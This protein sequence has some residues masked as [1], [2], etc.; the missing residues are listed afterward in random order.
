MLQ[1]QDPRER[2]LVA[3]ADTVLATV[4]LPASLF[5]RR[6]VSAP[7]RILLLRLE[8]IGDLLMTLPAIAAVRASAPG[9]DIDL[10]VGGWNAPIAACIPGLRRV[11]TLDA[12]WLARGKNAL[13]FAA[14]AARARRWRRERYDLAIN[15]EGDI[16]SN[17]LMWL[18]G[19]P[20]RAGFDMAG[21]G[22]LLTDAVAFD[23]RRHVS[24]NAMRLVAV[25]FAGSPGTGRAELQLPDD[26]R[27]AAEQLLAPAS[28]NGD[29]RPLVGI[30]ASGGRAI[31]QW[32]AERFAEVARLLREQRGAS[33][34]LTGTPDERALVSQVAGLL[35]GDVIDLCGRADLTTLAAVIERL[36]LLVTGDTG[37]MHL[38]AALG[39]P[40]VALF[41][42]SDPARWGPMH[43][44]AR[45]LRV[46]LP[47]SP[48]NRIRN[49]PARCVGHVPECLDRLETSSVVSAALDLLDRGRA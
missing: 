16:R 49:P 10:V 42:P 43:G 5:R 46:D 41:G 26:R 19:A 34:V 13:G 7:R 17:A 36:D 39:T 40:V 6:A 45:V 29:R 44:N 22:P 18:S 15:F 23:P 37:P 8:R 32:H 25:A 27:R 11:E 2:R 47:C 21:G 33:I 24:E 48:C 9:A 1:I 20:R 12:G 30:H 28:R 14:L 3:I 31:K 35:G 4:T 38:A